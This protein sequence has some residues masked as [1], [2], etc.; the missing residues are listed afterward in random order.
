MQDL[1]VTSHAC[2][3]W[4]ILILE[5]EHYH[6]SGVSLLGA[7][8]CELSRGSRSLRLLWAGWACLLSFKAH[9]YFY[10]VMPNRENGK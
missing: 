7:S 2:A 3:L 9:L 4:F 1:L 5:S 10:V 8:H 6:T